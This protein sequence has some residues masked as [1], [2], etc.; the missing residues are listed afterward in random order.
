MDITI[1]TDETSWIN[2]YLPQLVRGISSLGHNISLANKASEI[3]EGDLAFFLGC[4][5][6]VTPLTLKLNRH[7]LV[8]HESDLPNGRGWSPLTWQ[9]LEGINEVPIVLFEA[10][11]NVDSGI[12]YLKDKMSFTGYELI[13]DLRKVQAETSI[14]MCLEFLE[15]YPKIV[16]EGQAQHGEPTYYARRT[17]KNSR[18]DP[19]RTI[20]EQFNLLRVVDNERYPAYFELNG[21]I[22]ILRIE[23]E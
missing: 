13:D 4:G 19:D 17:P 9:V 12:V 10:G 22:Y 3:T 7:N 18:L 2:K 1:L 5:Q 16:P 15:R 8:V 14:R 11:E 23:L 20:R 21:K 6:L